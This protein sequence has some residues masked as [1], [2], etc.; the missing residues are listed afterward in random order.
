MH[1]K[2]SNISKRERASRP[3]KPE[4][5]WFGVIVG[6]I[7]G[8]LTGFTLELLTKP[9]ML[10]MLAA[11]FIGVALGF[12]IEGLRYWVRLR[13]FKASRRTENGRNL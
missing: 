3:A 11:G 2:R 13:R 12:A 5:A 8:W 7:A 6:M 4:F 9:M 1:T 10:L